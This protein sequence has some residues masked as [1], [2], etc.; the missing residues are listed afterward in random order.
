MALSVAH[1]EI[2]NTMRQSKGI[3][4]NMLASQCQL[5]T[6]QLPLWRHAQCGVVKE[7]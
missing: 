7:L 3:L 2:G 5:S 1:S 4:T 6:P